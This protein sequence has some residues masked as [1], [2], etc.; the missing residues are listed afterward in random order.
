MP[1][2]PPPLTAPISPEDFVDPETP[3]TAASSVLGGCCIGGWGVTAIPEAR[4]YGIAGR[5]EP[6]DDQQGFNGAV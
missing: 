6:V 4:S 2:A 5:V 1:T 3:Q